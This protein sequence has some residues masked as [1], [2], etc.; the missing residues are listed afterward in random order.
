[1]LY[2]NSSGI[3]FCDITKVYSTIL[4]RLPLIQ[5]KAYFSALLLSNENIPNYGVTANPASRY[6]KL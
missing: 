5:I 1:M 3:N 2:N 4:W 6:V